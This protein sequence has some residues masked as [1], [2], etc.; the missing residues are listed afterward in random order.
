MKRR[1]RTTST[2]SA[3]LQKRLN[4]YAIAT[5]AAGVNLLALA[6]PSEAEIVYTPADQT[7]TVAQGYSLDL[8][9][10]G[11]V[12][13]TLFDTRKE[14]LRF[15]TDQILFVKAAGRNQVNCPSSLCISSFVNAGALEAGT[16][17]SP[18]E[19][20]Y[21][22][23]TGEVNMALEGFSPPNSAFYS[24]QWVRAQDE[25][26]GLKFLIHGEMHYGWARLSVH[27]HGGPLVGR[28][29]EA[30]LT[31]YA[32]ETIPD[33]GIRAGQTEG[34]QGDEAE[35]SVPKSAPGQLSA[36]ALGASGL[37]LWRREYRFWQGASR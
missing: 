33:K 11:I 13:F 16:V 1:C 3:S 26:L 2:L 8:N 12:D 32:Y 25:Y 19:G 21:G 37:A 20:R 30:H 36:L 7:V 29:W 5:S 18:S 31:G 34:A 4:T 23:L 6:Q 28:T 22:W 15:S 24:Y 35:A 17:I 10:D 9:H 27:F 14:F